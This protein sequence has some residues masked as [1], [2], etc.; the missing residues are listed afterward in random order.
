MVGCGFVD[1]LLN[2]RLG[3]D[4]DRESLESYDHNPADVG[5]NETEEDEELA[6][7]IIRQQEEEDDAEGCSPPCLQ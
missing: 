2:Q 5:E 1:E 4:S 3:S 6:A 7:A